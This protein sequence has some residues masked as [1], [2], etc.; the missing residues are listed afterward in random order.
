MCPLPHWPRPLVFGGYATRDS[1]FPGAEELPSYQDSGD[2]DAP[3]CGREQWASPMLLSLDFWL[4]ILLG[5]C[6]LPVSFAL[7]GLLVSQEVAFR[8]EF[9]RQ[10]LICW[11]K[12]MRLCSSRI[13]N[14]QGLCPPFSGQLSGKQV[15]SGHPHSRSVLRT[16]STGFRLKM[17]PKVRLYKSIGT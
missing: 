13:S 3:G 11:I 16:R 14:F 12:K 17:F 6:F 15:E 10:C 2:S 7:N 5:L 8:S 9:W 1:G 4:L